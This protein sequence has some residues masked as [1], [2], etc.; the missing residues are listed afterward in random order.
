M[1][2]VFGRIGK[3][4]WYGNPLT[5]GKSIK[6]L[7]VLEGVRTLSG[8]EVRPTVERVDVPGEVQ[9][10]SLNF[11][12]VSTNVICGSG[13]AIDKGE[14]SSADVVADARRQMIDGFARG[15]PANYMQ[16][17]SGPV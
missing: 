14:K 7:P 12:Q 13:V 2:L 10:E 9:E 15:P 16:K 1:Y 3:D 6:D 4:I 8:R 5:A 17:C 11:H